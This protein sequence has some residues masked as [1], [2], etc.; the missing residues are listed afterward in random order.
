M[1]DKEIDAINY[2]IETID[3]VIYLLGIAQDGEELDRV[4]R[5][6][7]DIEYVEKIVS[8]VLLK[9]DPRRKAS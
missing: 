3:R 5:T 6:A 9:G 1:L 4:I 8:H 7:R 2:S